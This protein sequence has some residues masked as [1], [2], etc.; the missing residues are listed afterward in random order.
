MFPT[1][2]DS[3]APHPHDVPANGVGGLMGTHERHADRVPNYG[4]DITTAAG[5]T[6]GNAAARQAKFERGDGSDGGAPPG[7]GT[8][9]PPG[10]F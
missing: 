6:A 1:Q 4:S 9:P 8:Y 2:K 3:V 10:N 5:Q 7:A